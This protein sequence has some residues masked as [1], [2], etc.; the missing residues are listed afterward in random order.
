MPAVLRMLDFGLAPTVFLEGR[1]YVGKSVKTWDPKRL[2]LSPL[3]APYWLCV[4]GCWRWCHYVHTC[5]V[6]KA[7]V[8]LF[9]PDTWGDRCSEAV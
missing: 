8:L 7:L 6:P 4:C 5:C 1:A 3:S 2:T 9:L